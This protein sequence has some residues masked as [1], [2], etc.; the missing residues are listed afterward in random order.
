MAPLSQILSVQI[1][2]LQPGVVT[3]RH[4]ND[5]PIVHRDPVRLVELSGT[6]SRT[7][8][9][10]DAFALGVV[11]EDPRVAVAVGDVD[12]PVWSERDVAGSVGRTSANRLFP[13]GNLHQL[14]ALRRKLQDHRTAGID[15]PDVALGVD[16]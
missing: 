7:A 9:L 1:E 8:P 3:I 16:A 6:R 13:D 2:A 10:P 11:L 4:V 15:R 14:L 12:S 5:S